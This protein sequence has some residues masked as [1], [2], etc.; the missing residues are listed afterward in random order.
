MKKFKVKNGKNGMNGCVS[1]CHQYLLDLET[2]SEVSMRKVCT[3][4]V[5]VSFV[6]YELQKLRNLDFV[7]LIQGAL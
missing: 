6:S 3:D 7:A 4:C 2:E 5:G 1:Q